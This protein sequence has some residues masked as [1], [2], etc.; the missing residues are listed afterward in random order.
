MDNSSNNMRN[1][2]IVIPSPEFDFDRIRLADPISIQGGSYFTKIQ[3]DSIPLYIQTPKCITKQGFVKSGKKIYSDLVFNN[4]DETFVQ[5][6]IDL[7]TRCE[8][9]IYQ[10]SS[11]WF[12]NPLE[13]DDIE[14]A[15]NPS[16]KIHKTGNYI[17]RTNVKLNSLTNE[18]LLKL[19]NE[20]E[21]VLT[22]DDVI[23]DTN[24]IVILELKG[25]KFTTRNFQLDVEMKQVMV[26]NKDIFES[27]L[28][29]TTQLA[30]DTDTDTSL[31]ESVVSPQTSDTIDILSKPAADGVSDEIDTIDE[32]EVSLGKIDT[33]NTE[34]V[35]GQLDTLDVG[36]DDT[37]ND[38]IDVG[39][40][41]Q[42]NNDSDGYSDSDED[43]E[44]SEN[45]EYDEPIAKLTLGDDINL[46]TVET[47]GAIGRSGKDN[48]EEHEQIA[49]ANILSETK[50]QL[51]D[52]TNDIVGDVDTILLQDTSN[53]LAELIDDIED[54][55]VRGDEVI[56]ASVSSLAEDKLVDDILEDI[57]PSSFEDLQEYNVDTDL[58]D[59]DVMSLKKPSEYYYELYKQVRET[60]RQQKKS[61]LESY[62][63]AKNIKNT[64]MLDDISDTSDDVQ[65]IDS[66]MEED[67]AE[68]D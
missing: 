39:G 52:R 64:Y 58:A 43:S 60:A 23:P 18:P 50:P 61:A 17:L 42:E 6:L 22:M 45:S 24:I 27:C 55:P 5:W 10:K 49:T 41:N 40:V 9:L 16:V 21:H 12:Q 11:D 44:N 57:K 35:M 3:C 25:V 51:V 48:V 53:N 29:K 20:N 19:Y 15:F 37:K 34:D 54:L 36:V 31:G 26:L 7:E 2:S 62:L 56:Q 28:I 8:E 47:I 63:Q 30:P 13:L 14:S 68:A 67:A 46:D 66:D 33:L 59:G 38:L 4:N 1:S 32:V 65:Y